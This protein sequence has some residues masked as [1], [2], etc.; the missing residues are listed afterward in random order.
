MGLFDTFGYRRAGIG[1]A[2]EQGVCTMSGLEPRQGGGFY[3][4]RGGVL[5]PRVD[6]IGYERRVDWE[7]LVERL[8]NIRLENA[9]MDGVPSVQ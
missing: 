5:P 8:R 9:R 4:V 6:V 1:C 3:I 7:T 2:L